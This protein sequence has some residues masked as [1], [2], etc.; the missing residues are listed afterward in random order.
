[1]KNNI[2]SIFLIYFDLCLRA[3]IFSSTF[4]SILLTFNFLIQNNIDS[5]FY[6]QFVNEL[7]YTFFVVFGLRIII[8]FHEFITY[9]LATLNFKM[10]P[11]LGIWDNSKLCKKICFDVLRCILC[12]GKLMQI[13]YIIMRLQKIHE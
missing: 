9:L 4:I 1:M 8:I 3:Q 13:L 2:S 5:S 7:H 11:N 12:K 6:S 10:Y